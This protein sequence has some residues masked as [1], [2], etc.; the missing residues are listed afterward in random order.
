[1]DKKA[2][3]IEHD[4]FGL[5]LQA[6]VQRAGIYEKNTKH[7]PFQIS[8]HNELME[9]AKEYEKEVSEEKHIQNIIGL[10]DR[11]SIAHKDILAK[12]RF[13]IGP[14][15]KALN[16]YLKYLWCLGKIHEPPHC[17][18]D[19]IIIAE[20]PSCKK[21]SWTIMDDELEYRKLVACAKAK[22]KAQIKECT[23]IAVWELGVY[24]ENR[25]RNIVKATES[26]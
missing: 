3:F 26:K 2:E 1:M 11:L 15:Q 24:D 5:T 12:G 21:I 9:I 20:L 25:P 14:S 16:L 7:Q 6:T 22:A 10:S 19:A 13:R 18:F 4:I 17:P 8:L 23:S